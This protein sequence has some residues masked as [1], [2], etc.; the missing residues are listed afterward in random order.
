MLPTF[1]QA[2]SCLTGLLIW[3]PSRA[4]PQLWSLLGQSGP[5][6]ELR[7]PMMCLTPVLNAHPHNSLQKGVIV[8]VLLKRRMNKAQ[9]AETAWAG[10]DSTPGLPVSKVKTCPPPKSFWEVGAVASISSPASRRPSAP[11]DTSH[12]LSS[13]H[14][15]WQL[16]RTGKV[17]SA[18]Q[19]GCTS[20]TAIV[21]SKDVRF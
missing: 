4:E 6:P 1:A 5:S 8:P 14:P 11:G 20:P 9:W 16:A 7:S 19:P 21:C 18:L 10:W 15:A 3:P 17:A 13:F 12:A 2:I